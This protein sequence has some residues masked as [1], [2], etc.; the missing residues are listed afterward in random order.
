MRID[1]DAPLGTEW[2]SGRRALVTGGGG[3]DGGAGT[4]GWAIS[5]LFARHGAQAAV[6]DRDPVAAQR[7]VSQPAARS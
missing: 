7:T 6:L 3:R 5:R 4:I 2:M 1:L